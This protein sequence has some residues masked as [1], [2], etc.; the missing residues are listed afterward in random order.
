MGFFKPVKTGYCTKRY[1]DEWVCDYTT[2]IKSDY[3]V[4]FILKKFSGKYKDYDIDNV[5]NE[6]A[7]IV[8]LRVEASVITDT[9]DLGFKIIFRGQNV[10][11]SNHRIRT[12]RYGVI[13]MSTVAALAHEWRDKIGIINIE[14]S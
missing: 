4:I 7:V 10:I 9:V 11:F 1:P 13:T 5:D 8:V 3:F 14:K 2:L 12:L 6:T